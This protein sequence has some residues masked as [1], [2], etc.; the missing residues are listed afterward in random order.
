MSPSPSTLYVGGFGSSLTASELRELFARHGPIR[1]LRLVDRGDASFAYLS[2]DHLPDA[3]AARRQLDGL[4]LA[5]RTLRV[6]FAQ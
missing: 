6:A 3:E 4:R 1:D 2:F 5:D